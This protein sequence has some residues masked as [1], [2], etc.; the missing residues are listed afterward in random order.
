M[1]RE[2]QGSYKRGMISSAR[3]V[4][5]IA[6]WLMVAPSSAH[7]PLG[8]TQAD[9]A[10]READAMVRAWVDTERIPGAVLLVSRDGEVVFERVCG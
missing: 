7:G 10:I 2:Y 3:R 1:F 6:L 4:A 5:S 8:A 9:G